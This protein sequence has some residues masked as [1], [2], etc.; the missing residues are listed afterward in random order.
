M[1]KSDIIRDKFKIVD[2]E[3]NVNKAEDFYRYWPTIK[4]KPLKEWNYNFDKFLSHE[5]IKFEK[6]YLNNYKF[7]N[8]NRLLS[9]DK[10]ITLPT[11]LNIM[12]ITNSYDVVHSWF[13]P[14]IG[15]KFDCVPGRSTHHHIYFDK[16]G[17]YYG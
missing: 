4:Q 13:V 3:I 10:T 1:R 11:K 14:G 15:I 17:I 5:S 2:I 9:T 6:N 12:V 7:I 8:R 16:P